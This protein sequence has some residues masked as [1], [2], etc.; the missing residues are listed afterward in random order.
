MLVTFEPDQAHVTVTD[1][2]AIITPGASCASVDGHTARCAAP[3]RPGE[4]PRLAWGRVTLGDG[5]DRLST[6]GTDDYGQGDLL[7]L[8]GPGDDKIHGGNAKDRI[9]GGGGVDELRGGDGWDWLSDGDRD[10]GVGELAPGPDLLDSGPGE[11]ERLDYGK[12]T[13]G[14]TVDLDD[15]EADG[16][17]GEGDVLLGD[18]EFVYGGAGNDVI[19]GTDRPERF[20]GG[21]G[22]D[23]LV[24]RGGDDRF[25]GVDDDTISCGAG[26]DSLRGLDGVPVVERDCES[27]VHVDPAS[28]DE[29]PWPLYPVSSDGPLLRFRIPC[30]NEGAGEG[31]D[32]GFPCSARIRLWTA[33][34]R[35][36][37]LAIVRTPKFN[38]ARTVTVK[39]NRLGARLA[40]RADGVLATYDV[41]AK[42]LPDVRWTLRLKLPIDR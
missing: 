1:A 26:N 15:P 24:G 8:A 3:D 10:G 20:I 17:L 2:G 32:P 14:V 25:R 22:A 23:I 31:G 40:R 33:G 30:E 4:T 19:A 36:R 41:R 29:I 13:K 34:G 35:R 28:F 39:L 38:A 42:N 12:R 18:F 5:D 9:D 27:Y 6:A 16:A 37:P 7:V 11:R 21:A